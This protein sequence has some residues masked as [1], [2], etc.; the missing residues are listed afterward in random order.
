MIP[1]NLKTGDLEE[2]SNRLKVRPS[3]VL[4]ESAHLLYVR[5]HLNK[6]GGTLVPPFLFKIIA[7]NYSRG[8]DTFL[9]DQV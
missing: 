7:I 9:P 1:D 5:K 8:F 6:K 3:S 2:M 4:F